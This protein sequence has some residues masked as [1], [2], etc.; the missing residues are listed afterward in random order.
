MNTRC[1]HDNAQRMK[2]PILAKKLENEV[3][4]SIRNLGGGGLIYVYLKNIII[5]GTRHG[6]SGH[7]KN[8]ANGVCVYVST[9]KSSYAPL[10]DKNLLRYAVDERDF[11]SASLGIDGKNEFYDDASLPGEI[12]KRLVLSMPV[13]TSPVA[14]RGKEG[15]K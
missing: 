5:N 9:E 7:F 11:S 1:R 10:A 3:F 12:A 4:N 15:T 14:P 8:P 13:Y 2:N 6:C